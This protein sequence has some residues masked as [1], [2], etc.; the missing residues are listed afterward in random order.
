MSFILKTIGLVTLV[1][2]LVFSL[3]TLYLIYLVPRVVKRSL[4]TQ[5]FFELLN[6]INNGRI[7][8]LTAAQVKQDLT[9][10][11][12]ELHFVGTHDST[13]FQFL[14]QEIDLPGELPE[15]G[16]IPLLG[17]TLRSNR[18]TVNLLQKLQKNCAICQRFIAK[19]A[20]T[21]NLDIPSQLAIGVR[22]FDL[23]VAQGAGGVFVFSH[24]LPNEYASTVL[25]QIKDFLN[26]NPGEFLVISSDIDLAN[27]ESMADVKVQKDYA[28]LVYSIL[29]S[30]LLPRTEKL[31]VLGDALKEGYQVLFSADSRFSSSLLQDF[32]W[33]WAPFKG[34]WEECAENQCTLTKYKEQIQNYE[35]VENN[36]F[37]VDL[38]E[39]PNLEYMKRYYWS[40]I[41]H[42]FWG[43]KNRA[44]VIQRGQ[45]TQRE[46][47]CNLNADASVDLEK[48][49]IFWVDAPNSNFINAVASLNRGQNAM[50]RDNLQTVIEEYCTTDT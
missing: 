23:R 6:G 25:T 40:F 48:V 44:N 22:A 27:Q 26:S 33:I 28:R 2:L 9:K 11:I 12:N 16:N 7:A 35:P 13:A 41:E 47:L 1:G 4:R 10:R 20:F 14:P 49:N 42:P 46:W 36:L 15:A 5:N 30:K 34:K 39:T 29:G 21:Q 32:P 24:I 17:E 50:G 37:Q 31:P 43:G 18:V 19:W 38:I 45:R 3:A 8:K